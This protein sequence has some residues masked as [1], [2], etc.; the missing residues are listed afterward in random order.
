MK[1][2]LQIIDMAVLAGE[3]DPR[4]YV[5]KVFGFLQKMKPD[6]SLKIDDLTK[7]AS[8]DLFTEVVKLYMRSEPWQGNIAF[9][10]DMQVLKK[11]NYV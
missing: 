7:V 5:Q 3:G 6:T 9:S 11:T 1:I 8:R 10:E 2:P 4:A